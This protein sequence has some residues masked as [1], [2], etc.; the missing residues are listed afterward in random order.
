MATESPVNRTFKAFA[1]PTRLRILHLLTRGE[2]C[3][4]D[5][6]SVIKAPQPKISRHLAY[7]RGSGL[8]RARKMGL[9][10]YYS[11]AADGGRFTKRLLDCLRDCFQEVPAL[12]ADLKTLTVKK[13]RKADC[14]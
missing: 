14:G 11:L 6:M 3:V 5:I 13:C 4:C 12:K 9:W 7:L 8:V 2:L 10:V 1:D